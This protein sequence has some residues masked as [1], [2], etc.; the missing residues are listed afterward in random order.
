MK[1]IALTHSDIEW[2]I[3]EIPGA[4]KEKIA[5]WEKEGRIKIVEEATA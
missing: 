5:E 3:Q 2:F 4:T 1:A